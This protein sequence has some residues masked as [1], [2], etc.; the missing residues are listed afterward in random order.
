MV[1]AHSYFETTA[2][3]PP[4]VDLIAAVT[5]DVPTDSREA[6][7]AA[8][9]RTLLEVPTR[10]VPKDEFAA[11]GCNLTRNVKNFAKLFVWNLTEYEHVV[12]VDSDLLFVRDARGLFDERLLPLSLYTGGEFIA[13]Y[14]LGV[15]VLRPNATWAAELS[16]I[17]DTREWLNGTLSTCGE[18]DLVL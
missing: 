16:N 13:E 3:P 9:W 14:N 6:L 17:L 7:R 12:Q 1:V 18:N 10:V 5:S 4:A 8:G 15:Q 11:H 2:F